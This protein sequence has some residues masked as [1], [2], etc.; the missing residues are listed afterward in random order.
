MHLLPRSLDDPHLPQRDRP[1][2]DAAA[3]LRLALLDSRNRWRDV[4]LLAADLVLETDAAGR[5]A[6]LAPETVLG[7]V[8]D[9]LLGEPAALL[10]DLPDPALLASGGAARDLRLW[11]H[12][13][14][15]GAACLLASAA[16]LQDASGRAIGLRLA[17]RDITAEDASA[18]EAALSLR[19]MQARDQVADA[20][21]HAADPRRRIA[22]LL[23]GVSAALG[24]AAAAVL[25][26]GEGPGPA[27][28]SHL[29]GDLPDALLPLAAGL[30][31][32]SSR[33]LSPQGAP[34]ALLALDLPED[35]RPVLAALRRPGGRDWDADDHYM[36]AAMRDLLRPLLA[37]EWHARRLEREAGTDP[38][39]GLLNRRAFVD[40]LERRL[41]RLARGGRLAGAL[42]FLDLDNFKPVND[43]RG[44]A[45]GD[46]ALRRV[47]GLVRDGVRPAD[48]VG[49]LGGDEFAAW[50]D[51]ADGAV[52]G[53]RA[54][55]LL[56]LAAIEL[57]DVGLPGRPLMMSIGVA[58]LGQTPGLASDG[59]E[60][61]AALMARA[62]AAMYA[63]KRAGGARWQLAIPPGQP[64]PLPM[65]VSGSRRGRRPLH[66]AHPGSPR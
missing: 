29:Q 51:G 26:L 41:H 23:E 27:I 56:R 7:H 58:A 4:A 5:I 1:P 20:C 54:D 8:A 59:A 64:Q 21:L 34:L 2:P 42:L 15:G 49:R 10:L 66:P 13:A 24:L 22:A 18:S 52:G 57:R 43:E 37:V 63:A 38:L 60:D 14:D 55:V 33:F 19:R 16:A 17:A 44:H 30:V 45:A 9:R 65:P 61:A 47:A 28:A 40:G 3:A 48:L 50:L 31:P 39:T 11:A 46:A 35:R 32:G 12:R 36:L 25:D 53:M 6:F 62:D